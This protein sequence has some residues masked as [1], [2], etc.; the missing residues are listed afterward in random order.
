MRRFLALARSATLQ[1]LAE[2]LSAVLLLVALLIV[3]VAPVLH[4]HEFGE[5]GRLARD[6][7]F[8]ALLMFGLVFATASAVRAIGGEIESGTAAAALSRPVPRPLFFC[9]KVFGVMLA[10]G[11][12]FLAVS[13]ASI[14]A[15]HSAAVGA[16]EEMMGGTSRIWMPGL[17]GGV[18]ATLGAFILAGL[19]NRFANCRFCV[20]AYLLM[21]VVQPLALLAV[22]PCG[23]DGIKATL[24]E[25]PW[26]IFPA[27]LA[28][29]CGCCVFIALAG[30]LAVCLKP[31]PV[32]ALVTAGVFSSFV[33]PVRAI[34]PD[35]T[36]FWLVDALA[37]GGVVPAEEI[38]TAL[39]TAFFLTGFW[40]V[41]GAALMQ[42]REL[43]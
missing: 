25:M 9:A 38:G 12:F 22:A 17:S 41:A 42:R 1:A 18:C 36:R 5:P 31:A 34:L 19:L 6:C 21:L 7:G 3:H 26:Q 40:L 13:S 14:L 10:F 8:S 15:T 28:L 35:I 4:F 16:H 11:L 33:W 39:L 43:P 37:D 29:A 24:L 27:M 2:P 20:S 30:A 32:A 23:H